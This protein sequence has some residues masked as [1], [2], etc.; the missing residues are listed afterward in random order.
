M[1]KIFS[2]SCENKNSVKVDITT[3]IFFSEKNMYGNC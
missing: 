1:S 2:R 3:D